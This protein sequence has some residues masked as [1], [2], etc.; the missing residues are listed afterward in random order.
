MNMIPFIDYPFNVTN[1]NTLTNE[2]I[3][4]V[5]KISLKNNFI[6]DNDFKK[7]L[8]NKIWMD[9]NTIVPS[10]YIGVIINHIFSKIKIN[11]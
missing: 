5:K 3:I 8:I 6:L 9:Y 2:L 10:D 11:V 1:R 7:N 4:L